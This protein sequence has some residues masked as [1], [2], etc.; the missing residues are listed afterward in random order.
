MANGRNG[1]LLLESIAN[2]IVEIVARTDTSRVILIITPGY[3]LH[4]L[5]Q[6]KC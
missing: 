3:N 2:V 5:I 1:G 4:A 6:G